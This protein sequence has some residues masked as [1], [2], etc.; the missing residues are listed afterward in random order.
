MASI[1]SFYKGFSTRNYE[2]TGNTFELYNVSCIQEDLLNEI[3]T[4][5]GERLYMPTYGT[6]IPILIFE[7]NDAQTM[8]VIREDI[9]RVINN[10]PR[11]I[12][13]DLAVE[14]IPDS[15]SIFAVA[16][17]TYIAF[18]VTSDMQIIVTSR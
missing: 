5:R 1:I 10:D 4:I 15:Y 17:I 11:V 2:E 3:F 6:R 18:N 16:K 8:D 13:Q 14:Q 7:Q 9:T 12:L